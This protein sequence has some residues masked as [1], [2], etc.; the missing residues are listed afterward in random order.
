MSRL[1]AP[2][3][4]SLRPTARLI[5]TALA[6]MGVIISVSFI[7]QN[8]QSSRTVRHWGNSYLLTLPTSQQNYPNLLCPCNKSSIPWPYFISFYWIDQSVGQARSWNR[9]PISNYTE[10]CDPLHVVTA[11]V[12]TGAWLQGCYLMAQTISS[13]TNFTMRTTVSTTS[14]TA[15]SVLGHITSIQMQGRG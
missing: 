2:A 1:N 10:F 5:V 9:Y 11:N 7:Y 14:I 6:I 15:P 8:S 13:F 4:P 3:E 12:T